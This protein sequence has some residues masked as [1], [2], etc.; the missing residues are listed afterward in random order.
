MANFQFIRDDERNQEVANFNGRLISVSEQPVGQFPSGK[1]Y[2]IGTIQFENDKGQMVQRTCIIN[3]ANFD[4][5]MT[6]GNDYLCNAIIR[7]GQST[8]LLVCSHL[9]GS[10]SRADFSDFGIGVAST[11]STTK[12]VNANPLAV[13]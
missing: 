9:Q 3:K 10:S 5:G 11:T 2:H 6:E 12:V 1:E 4:K 8:V 13:A 7:D